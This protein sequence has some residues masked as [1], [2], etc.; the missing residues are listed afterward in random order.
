MIG[1]IFIWSGL[2][3]SQLGYHFW[4][5]LAFVGGLPIDYITPTLWLTELLSLLLILL[6]VKSISWPSWPRHYYL[7]VFVF[8]GLNIL[9]SHQPTLSL[10]FWLRWLG[11]TCL[12]L[13]VRAFDMRQLKALKLGLIF[14]VLAS[15]V[16][17][18]GQLLAQHSLGGLWY[19][20]GERRLGLSTPGVAKLVIA[21]QLWLRPYGSFSHP[22]SL[23]GF[24]LAV[25]IILR[26]I[27]KRGSAWWIWILV[28]ALIIL[29]GSRA[30]I[31]ALLVYAGLSQVKL[32]ASKARLI[33][34]GVGLAVALATVLPTLVPPSA[35]F[36]S[37]INQRLELAQSSSE[38]IN[39][40]PLEGVGGSNAIPA[41]YE[42]SRSFRDRL[43][44]QPV[45]NVWL[46]LW[47]ETGLVG[48]L[49]LAGLLTYLL[50][51][52]QQKQLW[53]W[54]SGWLAL[55]LTTV[56]DH[57]WLTLPQNRLILIVLLGLSLRKMKL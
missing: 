30:A 29:S 40:F 39:R 44:F 7:G 41:S 8:I 12:V 57:Y 16:L 47:L 42:Y 13:V 26:S 21:D 19:W 24:F 4:P 27:A 10:L 3:V 25:L 36:G 22:N 6:S 45:H 53:L 20:L 28:P 54:W 32:T 50:I 31:L 35:N 18:A 51:K 49:T 38:V 5:S 55:T 34:V 2:L 15:L 1:L 52:L 43:W 14:G 56:A 17:V 11:L 23:A 46:L 48:L 33:S 37:S 9:I